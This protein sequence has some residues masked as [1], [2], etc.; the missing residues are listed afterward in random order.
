VLVPCC[1]VVRGDGIVGGHGGIL[2]R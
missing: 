1:G 2:P